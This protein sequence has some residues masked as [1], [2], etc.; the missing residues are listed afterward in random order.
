ML[1]H[2]GVHVVR[3]RPL[4]RGAMPGRHPGAAQVPDAAVV[5][6]PREVHGPTEVVRVGRR[7]VPVGGLVRALGDVERV[8]A[9]LLGVLEQDGQRVD[10][11]AAAKQR[12]R[13]P[14]I[15]HGLPASC[16]CTGSR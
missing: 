13:E 7:V 15:R 9:E 2:H 6:A 14:G 12:P 10:V 16:R 11:G 5:T 8:R 1:H 3:P 4:V